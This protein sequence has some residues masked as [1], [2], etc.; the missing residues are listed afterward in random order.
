[1]ALPFKNGFELAQAMGF[2]KMYQ[3][4][5]EQKENNIQ[6][7][8]KKAEK[9][10]IR[11]TESDLHKIVKESVN[12]ILTEL[13]WPTYANAAKEADRRGNSKL[14][15]KFRTHAM[16]RGPQNKTHYND[17]YY[18]D[19]DWSTVGFDKEGNAYPYGSRKDQWGD[20]DD[21]EGFGDNN[22][23]NHE[24]TRYPGQKFGSTLD[25][26]SPET[27]RNYQEIERQA[28]KYNNGK[29]NY[30]DGHWQ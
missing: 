9:K 14:A 7:E 18:N 10:L 17:R 25:V 23:Y 28:K 15:D 22:V 29:L 11:L 8:S 19:Y 30:V 2:G 16:L 5:K 26:F 20:Y 12:K 1:M 3:A 24:T 13:E 27:K 6:A 21:I 4:S